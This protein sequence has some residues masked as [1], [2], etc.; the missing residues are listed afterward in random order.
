M[1]CRVI[2]FSFF[3]LLICFFTLNCCVSN[4]KKESP[5][6]KDSQFKSNN[7]YAQKVSAGHSMMVSVAAI[8]PNGRLILSG[9][10]DGVLKLWEVSTGREIQ[11]FS[12]M[13]H[14]PTALA[15]APN[16]RQIYVGFQNGSISKWDILSGKKEWSVLPER[17]PFRKYSLDFTYHNVLKTTGRIGS[18]AVSPDGKVLL[19]GSRLLI[20]RNASSGKKIRILKK[21]AN[22]V[23]APSPRGFLNTVSCIA[24]APD[25][26]YAIS[27]ADD[28]SLIR[29]KLSSG[30]KLE[31]LHKPSFNASAL[32]SNLLLRISSNKDLDGKTAL[33]LIDKRTQHTVSSF[34][35]KKL[36][37]IKAKHYSDDRKYH[38]GKQSDGTILL[39]N[40]TN[41][42]E[43]ILKPGWKKNKEGWWVSSQLPFS[44][45][46]GIAFGDTS[47]VTAVAISP[48]NQFILT[49]NKDGILK[50]FEINSGEKTVLFSDFSQIPSSISFIRGG[51]IAKVYYSGGKVR[52]FSI[53]GGKLIQEIT[54]NTNFQKL[55][56]TNFQ[57]LLSI[58]LDGKYGVFAEED[59]SIS[60]QDLLAYRTIKKFISNSGNIINS[61]SS[62]SDGRYA[63]FGTQSGKLQLWDLN[64]AK[65]V[66]SFLG[67]T[68]PTTSLLFSNDNKRVLSAAHDNKM[69]LWDMF[70]GKILSTFKNRRGL[71]DACLIN[72][73]TNMI[74]SGSNGKLI[75]WDSLTGKQVNSFEIKND[76]RI[77]AI[78]RDGRLALCYSKAGMIIIVDITNSKTISEIK[79]TDW[80]TIGGFSTNKQLF[81]TG[82]LNSITTR[83]IRSGNTIRTIT[84]SA[85][86]TCATL[87]PDNKF[88]LAGSDD[89]SI[90]IWEIA[91]GEILKRFYGHSDRINSVS[92]LSQGRRILSG[93]DDMTARLWD[94]ESEQEILKMVSSDD[95]E[96][97]VATPDG[98]YDTSSEGNNLVHWAFP[99][100]MET[101]SFALFEE[102]F[103]RSDVINSRLKGDFKAGLPAPQITQ[104]PIIEMGDHLSVKNISFR[105]YT[106]SV[107]LPSSS[108]IKKLRTYVN[109]RPAL[110]TPVNDNESEHSLTI[111]LNSGANRVTVIAY[112]EKGLSSNPKY[113][114][115]ICKDPN[116]SRPNLHFLGIGVS[117]YPKLP[118]KWQLSFA[119]TDA[120]SLMKAFNNQKGK[121]FKEVHSNLITNNEATVESISESLN[122]LTDINQS[123]IAVIFMAGHGIKDKDGTFYFLTSDGNLKELRQGGLSWPVLTKYISQ[124]KGRVILLLD[125]CHSGSIVTETVVPN[126][127]L[128]QDFFSG[129]RGGVMVFSASKGRQ[130]SFESPD[131]GEGA[132]IFTYAFIQGLTKK[133]NMVDINGNGFVEFM[134]LVDYVSNYVDK[135]TKGEQTP[136]L[137]RKELFG[138]LPIA[139]VTN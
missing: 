69:I 53:P 43:V 134:E 88:I 85:N 119:H 41:N 83:D 14:S 49:A 101:F 30:K 50:L 67:H 133:S 125:A 124:I 135:E 76:A 129:K 84:H 57:K 99:G 78:S 126:N 12:G 35:V 11:T 77:I 106:F 42:N 25:N 114:D 47:R 95:G 28:G 24:V 130:Y 27:G 116:L 111:P 139:T 52:L 120:K 31:V 2:P 82:N 33:L 63:I 15:F 64:T 121:M 4:S 70:S 71:I 117:D 32:F 10:E 98:Y 131:I 79:T 86:F 1:K 102:H 80:V 19:S 54:T 118:L 66:R 13:K 9:S 109:G 136:R 60:L 128:A 90:G 61:I 59:G 122:D 58:S 105:D 48:H 127:E 8:S 104:P 51:Q 74:V 72:I 7:S 138:D 17:R 108:D 113:V 36:N 100:I 40:T 37:Q 6:L 34:R 115:V 38:F 65:H 16:C 137:S 103:K 56:S 44:S 55:L 45:T 97:M 18:L 112:D 92:F 23:S 20:L 22:L 110:E 107:K 5:F 91:T 68:K 96:W 21:H 46:K 89:D 3:F 87:S 73:D 81:F 62:S 123:D 75:Y 132:G 39:T 94:I 26:K 93:S 29:W